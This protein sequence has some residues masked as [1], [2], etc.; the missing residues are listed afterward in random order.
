MERQP[1]KGNFNTGKGKEKDVAG[2]KKAEGPKRKG[3]VAAQAGGG[4]KP[5]DNQKKERG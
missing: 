2:G 3:G 1:E 5:W 4:P